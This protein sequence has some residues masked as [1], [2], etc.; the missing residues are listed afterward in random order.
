MRLAQSRKLA[1]KEKEVLEHFIVKESEGLKFCLWGDMDDTTSI[2]RRSQIEILP[3]YRP[4]PAR[5]SKDLEISRKHA[6]EVCEKFF[7][8]LKIFS[9][10]NEF[11]QNR[12][13]K[14]RHYYLKDDFS[15]FRMLVKIIVENYDHKKRVELLNYPFLIRYVNS[16]L[17]KKILADKKAIISR[18][19]DII[20][21]KESEAEQFF[22]EVFQKRPAAIDFFPTD[23]FQ[24]YAKGAA[25]DSDI[26]GVVGRNGACEHLHLRFPVQSNEKND[27][28]NI[29]T[30]IQLHD[31][32]LDHLPDLNKYPSAID[33]YYSIDEFEQVILPFLALILISPTVLNE[34]INTDWSPGYEKRSPDYDIDGL[35]ELKFPILFELIFTALADIVKTRTVPERGSLS[36]VWVKP[37]QLEKKD[38]DPLLEIR[39]K[40][41][42]VVRFN[43][44]FNTSHYPEYE[45]PE[46]LNYQIGEKT[47]I[48]PYGAF[49]YHTKVKS[50]TNIKDPVALFKMLRDK[51]NPVS[52]Y[53][54]S[55]FTHKFNNVLTYIDLT[56]EIP[57]YQIKSLI[58]E[59]NRILIKND[60]AEEVVFKEF[61]GHDDPFCYLRTT[62]SAPNHL[63]W[64]D[65]DEMTW[66]NFILIVKAFPDAF[67]IITKEE[68]EKMLAEMNPRR[69]K[70]R[71][72]IES[73]NSSSPI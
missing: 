38:D 68:H 57:D 52:R 40:Q 16:D 25:T 35:G 69:R 58:L 4:H 73:T 6:K 20:N 61:L 24:V 9:F 5:L 30:V 37:R 26:G 17:V 15:T 34:F 13:E 7:D 22:H 42:Y 46:R 43:V 31:F 3:Y 32:S 47:G 62:P 65:F 1:P 45:H 12:V 54:Q 51:K 71:E 41:G 21:W 19:V 44:R 8:K 53:L 2:L 56:Q 60:L 55:K 59:L 64:M 49:T 23:S 14:T 36:E 29:D 66:K 50:I 33:D 10:K 70:I 72:Q 63:R 67:N 48:E 27:R 28:S 18:Q 11:T 39:F